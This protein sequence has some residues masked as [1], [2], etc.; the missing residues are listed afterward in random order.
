VKTTFSLIV[1]AVLLFGPG[2]LADERPCDCWIDAKTGKKVPTI[3]MGGKHSEHTAGTGAEY[4]AN[5]V[6]FGPGSDHAFNTKTGQNYVREP[7]PPPGETAGETLKK[8]FDS[9]H[10]GIGIGGGYTSGHDE[11]HHGEDRHRTADK[12]STDKTKA[13]TTSPTTTHKTVTSACKCDPCTC[14]PCTCH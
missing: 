7:C 11:H 4:A 2:L 10:I 14:A 8:V 6:H 5:D 12:V 3:P 1:L 9:V 13:H